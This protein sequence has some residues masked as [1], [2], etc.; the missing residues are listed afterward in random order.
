LSTRGIA[1]DS[2]NDEIPV[3]PVPDHEPESSVEFEISEEETTQRE[4]WEGLEHLPPFGPVVESIGLA[5][6][7]QREE[8]AQAIQAITGLGNSQASHRATSA[9]GNHLGSRRV[10][11]S[12]PQDQLPFRQ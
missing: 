2:C 7:E 6:E 5:A 8:H 10:R 12:F 9:T 1:G 11:I 4:D 3:T